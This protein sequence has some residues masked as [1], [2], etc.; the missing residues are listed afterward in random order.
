MAKTMKS[1]HK[2][3]HDDV[4]QLMLH[5]QAFYTVLY[6]G[7]LTLTPKE[8]QSE[9]PVIHLFPLDSNSELPQTGRTSVL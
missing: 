9:K 3:V 2:P 1:L 4:L 5:A 6:G 8:Q 7:F